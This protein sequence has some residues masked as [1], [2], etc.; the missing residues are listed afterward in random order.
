MSF[1]LDRYKFFTN[2]NKVVA[3]SS[4]AG[5]TVRGTAKC[6][7]KDSFNLEKGKK[8][9]AAR[10]NAKVAKKRYQRAL[11]KHWEAIIAYEKAKDY[12]TQMEDYA[13]SS[14]SELVEAENAVEAYLA[15]MY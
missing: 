10:C 2:E 9:A 4:Y 11:Q 12:L 8:L 6:D 1:A 14:V 15:E 7:P 5:K 3:V 13:A